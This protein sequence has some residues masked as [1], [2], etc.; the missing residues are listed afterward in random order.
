MKKFR[1]TKINEANILKFYQSA[2]KKFSS[3]KKII[4]LDEEAAYNL[5]YESMLKAS[6]SLLLSYGVRPRSLPGHHKNIIEFS[7]NKLGKKY[8]S[9]INIFDRMRRKRNKM[10]YTV[11]INVS[12]T[13][14]KRVLKS[15]EEYLKIIRLHINRNNKQ[16]NLKI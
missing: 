14:T 13:D 8:S 6:L 12:K 1:K 11:D 4:R 15:T 9:L 3:A 10:L 5:L 2:V 16:L 7:E